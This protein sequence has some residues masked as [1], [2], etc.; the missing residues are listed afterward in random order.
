MA[1]GPLHEEPICSG[2][3]QLDYR[4]PILP[5]HARLFKQRNVPFRGLKSRF[6]I[7]IRMLAARARLASFLPCSS[8]AMSTSKNMRCARGLE[9]LFFSLTSYC[10]A[11]QTQ[12]IKLKLTGRHSTMMFNLNLISFC[13]VHRGSK[14]PSRVSKYFAIV[15]TEGWISDRTDQRRGK[16]PQWNKEFLW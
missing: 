16:D 13:V 1:K 9:Y 11:H 5:S 6:L 4:V 7:Q 8:L 14:L 15:K 2:M 12:G 10:S 3:Y